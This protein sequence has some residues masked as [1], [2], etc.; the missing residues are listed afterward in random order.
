[1]QIGRPQLNGKIKRFFQT[2]KKHR[3]RFETLDESLTFH[4]EERP[5]MNLN[6]DTLETPAEA[7]ERLVPSPAKGGGDPPATEVTR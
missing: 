3:Q 7:F 4:N 2:Y 5:H 6:W 1:M